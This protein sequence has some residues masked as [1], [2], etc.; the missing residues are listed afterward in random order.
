MTRNIDGALSFPVSVKR[1]PQKGLTVKIEADERERK[2]MNQQAAA[3]S[4]APGQGSAGAPAPW[5]PVAGDDGNNALIP[6][7]WG[8]DMSP[9]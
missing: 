4:G 2:L 7:G 8:G 3:G 9:W 1:L 5:A 6:P